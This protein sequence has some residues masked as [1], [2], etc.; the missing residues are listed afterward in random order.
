[1]TIEHIS[2][3]P[4]QTKDLSITTYFRNESGQLIKGYLL[5]EKAVQVDSG[6]YSGVLFINDMDGS[7]PH[8][9]VRIP[10]MK[11]GLA[12]HRRS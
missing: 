2:G 7:V 1:M 9:R 3:S 4:L 11:A 10:G 5:G 12:M 8:S 6:E